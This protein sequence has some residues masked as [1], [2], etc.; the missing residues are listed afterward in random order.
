MQQDLNSII[1][2][3]GEL[4]RPFSDKWRKKITAHIRTLEDE[5]LEKSGRKRADAILPFSEKDYTTYSVES[6]IVPNLIHHHDERFEEC[7]ADFL[8]Q[9]EGSELRKSIWTTKQRRHWDSHK[10]VISQSVLKSWLKSAER[11]RLKAELK[12][13][14]GMEYVPCCRRNID[15]D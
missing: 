14:K 4:V 1:T 8:N 3:T 6:K 15:L 13:W 10:R 5:R 12:R 9:V 2:L 11:S 7:L